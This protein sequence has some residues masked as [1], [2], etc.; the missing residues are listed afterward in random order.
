MKFHNLNQ[1]NLSIEDY[2]REFE[3]LM[4]KRDIHEPEE[5]TI[6]RFLGGLKKELANAVRLQPY[7]TFHD[8]RKLALQVE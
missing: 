5:Q 8:V 1:F 6:V 7:W 2:T 3:Y 4:L